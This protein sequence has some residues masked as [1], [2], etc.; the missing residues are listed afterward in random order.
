VHEIKQDG[1]RFIC[2]RDGDRVRLFTRRGHDWTERLPRVAEA[3]RA[4]PVSSAVIDGE[5]VACDADGVTNFD[6]LRSALARK[7][8]WEPFL[9][10]FD[11]LELDG[12]D[13]R[14]DSWEA[15]RAALASLL[16]GI[17]DGIV[18]SEH[19]D[20]EHGPAMFRHACRLGLEGI[21]SKRRDRHYRSGRSADWIKV[22]NPAAP[23]ATRI[24]ESW[25]VA[26]PIIGDSAQQL[27]MLCFVCERRNP[28]GNTRERS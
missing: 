17:G 4:L 3:L 26:A 16:R 27:R 28:P 13:L 15:R 1:Y 12:R 21:V 18:L 8:A 24:I 11:V 25:T 23:A 9:Y 20:G 2:R 6:R 5:A 10:A 7:T 22:K 19:M 14:P